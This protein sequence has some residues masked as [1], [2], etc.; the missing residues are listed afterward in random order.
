MTWAVFADSHARAIGEILT[1][2]SERVVAIV[3]GAFLE[4]TVERTLKERLRDAPS[5]IKTLLEPDNP[6]GNIAPQVDL[7]H[8]LYAFE[9]NVRDALKGLAR[10]RNFFAHNLAAS[11]DSEDKDFVK[12]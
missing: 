4:E 2:G 11:F 7:L 6:L 9:A 10:V 5:I 12:S 8:L 3:G 1:T